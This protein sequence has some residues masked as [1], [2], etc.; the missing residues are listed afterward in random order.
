[1]GGDNGGQMGDPAVAG[2][3]PIF[4]MHH[5]N[6]DRMLAL[7]P[8]INYTSFV[9]ESTAEDGSWVYAIGSEVDET[10]NLGPFWKD[11]NSYWTSDACRDFT[12]LGYTYPEFVGLDLNNKVAVKQAITA[13]VNSLYGEAFIR[14][15]PRIFSAVPSVLG[16]QPT[17]AAQKPIQATNPTPSAPAAHPTAAPAAPAGK[18]VVNVAATSA[19]PAAEP[20]SVPIPPSN[21]GSQDEH[22]MVDWRVRILTPKYK[23]GGSYSVLV[24]LGGVPEQVSEWRN[25]E[26]LVGS[27]E[28]FANS[29][30][31]ACENCR[32]HP[33]LTYEGVVYLNHVLAR[34]SLQSFEPQVI[35]PYLKDNLHWRVLQKGKVIDI[36]TQL[37]DLNVSVVE[38]PI[39]FA[40]GDAMPHRVGDVNHHATITAGKDGGAS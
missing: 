17:G 10:T 27:V 23:L 32:N 16:K 29:A 5:A 11:D 3:D 40:P 21:P 6:V 22:L 2:H 8:A 39:H 9:P 25:S 28:V 7:W 20:H 30:A 1:V 4:F 12:V 15:R 34:S 37:P 24:F 14:P 33:D 19:K 38:V 35:S 26:E 18:P 13:K 31:G 36:P